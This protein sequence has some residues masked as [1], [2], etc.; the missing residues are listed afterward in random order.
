[1]YYYTRFGR[2]WYHLVED[3]LSINMTS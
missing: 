2:T 1:L 3:S